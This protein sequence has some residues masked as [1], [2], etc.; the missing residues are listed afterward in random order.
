MILPWYVGEIPCAC[1]HGIFIFWNCLITS[2]ATLQHYLFIFHFSLMRFTTLDQWLDWQT[3]VHP[4]EI[5]LGLTRVNTVAKR[6]NLLKPQFPI[7]TVAGTNG[8]GSSTILLDAIL[9][10]A[11]YRVGRYMSPHLLRYNER[12]C[13]AGVEVSE[14]QLCQAFDFIDKAREDIALTFFEFATLAAMWVFQHSEI[15]LAVLEVGLGG[16]LD[17]VNCFDADIAL[18]TA[19]DIDHVE[20]LGNDRESIGFEKA[21][22]FRAQRPAVCSDANPPMSLIKQAEQLQTPLYYQGRDFSYIKNKD[23]TWTWQSDA[24]F[25]SNSLSDNHLPQPSLL[26]DFQLQNAAGVL[27]VLE[28]LNQSLSISQAAVHEGLVKA[29]LPG[30]FQVFPGKITRI[31][32]VAHNPLGARVLKAS[33]DQMP[34]QGETYAVVGMLKE[35][36]IAGFFKVMI[37]SI[38]HW[39]V[40]ALD[41]ERTASAQCLVEHL[42]ALG[43]TSIHSYSS[44]AAAYHHVE[45]E[46][47]PGDRI[48]VCGSFYTVKIQGL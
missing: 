27:M 43:A 14:A 17:A 44:I 34:C 12:I 7:I 4:R 38:T 19:I 41:T 20:W 6:L 36:D 47:Q 39:H 45:F 24:P 9:S 18:V 40:A 21:G 26:G 46:A 16:R 25:P 2:S 1:P 28:L 29:N 13:I 30:R 5:A 8:K 22:I 33:L 37:E 3:T 23:K 10:A 48:V 32:D 42:T 11:G 35:K 15:D 31:F